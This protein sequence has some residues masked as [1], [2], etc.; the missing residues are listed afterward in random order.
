MQPAGVELR[1]AR[2]ERRE[3]V[4]QGWVSG[5]RYPRRGADGSVANDV[6]RYTNGANREVADLAPRTTDVVMS[7]EGRHGA[8]GGH[9]AGDRRRML[10]A[11][12]HA[13]VG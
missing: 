5:S 8:R 11:K 10:R 2:A 13:G 12:P 3:H 4:A 1:Q 7:L 9:Q 6:A